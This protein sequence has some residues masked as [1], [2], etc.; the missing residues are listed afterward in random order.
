MAGVARLQ[1][2]FMALV[3][4]LVTVTDG[5]RCYSCSVTAGHPCRH[6]PAG[7]GPSSVTQCD[8]SSDS[9]V[10]EYS[11]STTN[12]SVTE[13][14]RHCGHSISCIGC[15]PL[16]NTDKA[17]CTTCCKTDLCN[18][19]TGVTSGTTRTAQ[20]HFLLWAAPS[21]LSTILMTVNHD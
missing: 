17:V 19:D 13:F 11:Y 15:L 20:R 18:T 21:L 8:A 1:M 12:K 7:L 5:L 6:D 3:L 16:P 2:V 9:C 4:L 10:T 14:G